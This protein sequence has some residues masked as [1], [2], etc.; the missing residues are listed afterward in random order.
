MGEPPLGL[1]VADKTEPLRMLVSRASR[2]FSALLPWLSS[3]L[4][5]TDSGKHAMNNKDERRPARRLP[6]GGCLI[7][8]MNR[9]LL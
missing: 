4:A 5:A 8:E 6:W 9:R 7:E 2:F 1:P 3:S